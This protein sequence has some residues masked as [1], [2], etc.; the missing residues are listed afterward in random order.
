MFFLL[1]ESLLFAGQ[2][3][4]VMKLVE[5]QRILEPWLQ[6]LK[7]SSEWPTSK[8]Y[9]ENDSQDPPS[10]SHLWKL[11]CYLSGVAVLRASSSFFDS[12]SWQWQPN[13][14]FDNRCCCYYNCISLYFEKWELLAFLSARISKILS[15]LLARCNLQCNPK[16]CPISIHMYFFCSPCNLSQKSEPKCVQH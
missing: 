5:S 13:S 7:R 12:S 10:Q 3:H 8:K 15:L 9:D 6:H 4:S 16:I 1:I 2:F 14:A 11:C